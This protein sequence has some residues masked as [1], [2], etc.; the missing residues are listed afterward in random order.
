M[1]KKLTKS[2]KILLLLI[3]ISFFALI[4]FNAEAKDCSG[5]KVASHKWIMCKAGSDKY[6][7]D[8]NYTEEKAKKVKKGKCNTLLGCLGWGK[9]KSRSESSESDSSQVSSESNKKERGVIK[10][11]FKKIKDLG[12]KNIGEEG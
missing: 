12:G 1:I 10:G 8:T 5:F 9:N 3:A 2:T 11:F 4:P 6:E 7:P